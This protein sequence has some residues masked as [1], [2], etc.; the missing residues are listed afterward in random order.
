MNGDKNPYRVL[1]IGHGEVGRA[2]AVRIRGKGASLTAVDPRGGQ[3]AEGEAILKS[4][5]D[6]LSGFDLVLAAVPSS[7]ALASAETVRDRDSDLVYVDLSSSPVLLMSRCADLFENSRTTFVDAAIMGSVD[8]AGA[9]A[10]ITIAG[11]AAAR[12][13]DS[14][15]ALGLRVTV[16][17]DSVPGD[18]SG[19]K[20]VRSILMK[21]IEA[22]AAECYAVAGRMGLRDVLKKDL[23]S[24]DEK[25]FADLL[26]AMVRTHPIH[27]PRRVLEVQA[28]IDQA[29]AL[30]LRLPLTE[31]VR[32][33]FEATCRRLETSPPGEMP[34]I[35]QSAKWITGKFE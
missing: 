8:L 30:G 19:L 17:P 15:T 20:L 27:A 2:L 14:L 6:D 10:P 12:T 21:G 29:N 25:P 9:D 32:T 33:S 26:D 24:I 18:A 11:P 5:P 3:D 16:L 22:V 4:V 35:H 31:T 23:A 28:A 1:L 13:G 34:D 7:A